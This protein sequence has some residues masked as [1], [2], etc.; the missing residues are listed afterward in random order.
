[1]EK[2]KDALKVV[3]KIAQKTDDALEDGKV[4]IAEG[5]SLALSSLAFIKVV[6]NFD[7][8][9]EEY[10]ALSNEQIIDLNAWF[11]EEFDISNDKVEEVVEGLF[12]VLL[13][14]KDVLALFAKD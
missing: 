8:I 9:Y 5:F 13:N 11:I 10:E 1:M 12:I 6:K 4:N 3:I 14:L 7:A 2:L